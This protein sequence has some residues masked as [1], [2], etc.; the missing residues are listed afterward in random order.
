MS[1][2]NL[3]IPN[4]ETLYCKKLFADELEVSDVE[5]DN[6][7]VNNATILTQ[8]TTPHINSGTSAFNTVAT[9]DLDAVNGTVVNL[10]STNATIDN[11]TINNNLTVPSLSTPFINCTNANVSNNLNVGNTATVNTLNV[12]TT[13]TAPNVNTN[14]ITSPIGNISNLTSSVITAP[15]ANLDNISGS[16]L[17]YTTGY[18]DQANGSNL[19][20]GTGN[21]G[22]ISGSNL[23]YDTGYIPTLSTQE[24]TIYS[25]LVS[26]PNATVDNLTVNN[27]FTANQLQTPDLRADYVRS[28][29]VGKTTFQEN[30]VVDTQINCPLIGVDNIQTNGT[31]SVN[32]INPLIAPTIQLS[33]VS[34]IPSTPLNF[35][36]YDNTGTVTMSG[37]I[38]PTNAA[39][40]L[41]RIGN[42][43]SL[44]LFSVPTAVCTNNASPIVIS[45]IPSIVSPPIICR[46]LVSILNGATPFIGRWNLGGTTMQI[47]AGLNP[48]DY[49][50]L[51]NICSIAGGS[52]NFQWVL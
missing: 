27:S 46:G 3:Y 14:N 9:I 19:S 1:V 50:T 8:V 25:A 41:T 47:N 11:L 28:Y 45:G 21:I 35:Y 20:Y 29:S 31:G 12:N 37:A 42:L 43:V 18:I 44:Q 10:E 26:C 48:T 17:S 22:D 2:S 15:S 33:T 7:I 4:N 24:L 5:I 34:G 51:G 40:K 13:V 38:N 36:Y 49:W 52:W 6:V 30:V 39:Y 16:N 32:V 23:T